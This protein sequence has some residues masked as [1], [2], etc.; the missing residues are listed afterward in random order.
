[1]GKSFKPEG[2]TNIEYFLNLIQV[3]FKTIYL[4]LGYHTFKQN[5]VVVH[6]EERQAFGHNN[7]RGT[8]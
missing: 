1:M 8:P 5:W 2:Q 3:N 7:Q 4:E 6:I